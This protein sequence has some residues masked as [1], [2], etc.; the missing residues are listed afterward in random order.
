MR[1]SINQ[2]I[3]QSIGKFFLFF[4]ILFSF[5]SCSNFDSQKSNLTFAIKIPSESAFSKVGNASKISDVASE[6]NFL[7]NSSN[8]VSG[9]NFSYARYA[10]GEN[11]LL[12]AQVIDKNENV[13][14][15][16]N[17]N[18]T[19][20]QKIYIQFDKVRASK[21]QIAVKI[22][23]LQDN[24]AHFEGVS[25]FFVMGFSDVNVEVRMKPVAID[26]NAGDGSGNGDATGGD[27]D[28]GTSSGNGESGQSGGDSGDSGGSQT[29]G[30]VIVTP[31]YVADE[32]GFVT[33][34]AISITGSETWTPTSS[35]FV[36]GRALQI[37][38][39]MICDHEVT[40]EEYYSVMSSDTSVNETNK[41][42]PISNITWLDAV[43]YCNARS[44][45]EELT[46]YYY[47]S[48]S[49][50]KIT[51]PSQWDSMLSSLAIDG[52]VYD[53]INIEFDNTAN[54]YRLPFEAEWEYAAR[55]G[56]NFTYAG[57]DTLSDVAIDYNASSGKS[58]AEVKSKSPNGYNLYDMSGHVYE[59]CNDLYLE[60]ITSSITEYGPLGLSEAGVSD[61]K[62]VQRGGG[63]QGSNA[64]DFAVNA[65]DKGLT[66]STS[67]GVGF[68]VV[69]SVRE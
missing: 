15:Q 3:N 52:T 62:C 51:D 54:G 19:Y 37:D 33:L 18:A 48:D 63:Y 25:D 22:E 10:N 4:I 30:D 55:G 31:T 1:Q 59:W 7:N 69:R 68:R 13:I 53:W 20:N 67:V 38:S 45:N 61:Y 40:Q 29:G 21:R 64:A 32:K 44:I 41:N 6:D 57:S 17:I 47:I 50:N 42:K 35:V 8:I 49:G 58:V 14:Q 2:S 23:I 24:V 46:P 12:K 27:S 66:T 56:Q 34:P 11:I 43:K 36:S 5:F 39:F 9:D 26:D 16:K 28:D 65:R 60:T